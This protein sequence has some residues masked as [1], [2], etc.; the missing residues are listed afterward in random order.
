MAFVKLIPARGRSALPVNDV[1]E[2]LRAEFWFVHVDLDEGQD[3]VASTIAATL[4]LSDTIPIMKEQLEHLL[5]VQDSAVYV[6]FGDHELGVVAGCCVMRDSE[7]FFGQVDEVDGPARPLVE[8]AAAV[9]GYT[10]L[11]G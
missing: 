6:R 7:L 2:R 10:V 5:S 11:P 3:Q 4:K 1:V 9:L 8:R